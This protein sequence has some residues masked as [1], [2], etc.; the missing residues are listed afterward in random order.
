MRAA[1]PFVVIAAV[2]ICTSV[3]NMW[4]EPSGI[5]IAAFF[6]VAIIL[7]SSVSRVWRSTELR[8]GCITLD[9][10][11][12]DFVN[13]AS[14]GD[15]RIIANHL[16][17]GDVR[18]Y[19]LKEKEVREDTHLPAG[20]P[21]LFFEVTVRDAS[22]FADPLIVKGV[23]VDCY[24]VLRAESSAVPNAIAAFL[25]YLRDRTDRIPHAYFGWADG[26]P[27]LYGLR[28]IVLGEG[29]TALVTRKILRQAE[30]DPERRPVLHIGGS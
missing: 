22:E 4:D 5:T 24:R 14:R 16:D 9:T 10:M 3:V 28:Y 18:E 30:P 1:W 12:E 15:I 20:E 2:F 27:I 17:T 13:E 8:V 7:T 23:K 26:N 6:V 29:D 21:V 11:A 19:F 25:L